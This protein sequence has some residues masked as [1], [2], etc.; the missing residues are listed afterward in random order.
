MIVIKP[1][2]R[3]FLR[4]DT[5][6]YLYANLHSGIVTGLQPLRHF[7]R[8]VPP[9]VPPCL[10]YSITAD[11]CCR[12]DAP[13]NP[14]GRPDT[15]CRS[16]ATA[17]SV[18]EVPSAGRPAA[19]TSGSTT[20]SAARCSARRRSCSASSRGCATARLGVRQLHCQLQIR[21]AQGT[22]PAGILQT[23]AGGAQV[24]PV[25]RGF[26]LLLQHPFYVPRQHG[27]RPFFIK[28]SQHNQHSPLQWRRSAALGHYLS[29]S[30]QMRFLEAL[31]VGVNELLSLYGISLRHSHFMASS[32]QKIS[33][34]PASADSAEINRAPAVQIAFPDASFR[35]PGQL[36]IAE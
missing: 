6:I 7:Q 17:R 21:G 22:Q 23:T 2:W 19:G 35:K 28:G 10:L 1:C 12:R 33:T 31:K 18:A 29:S 27:S 14:H 13:Q 36:F 8:I 25:D 9:G 34:A 11:R 32:C 5:F 26:P 4:G 3:C 20:T 24:W 16:A 30:G 15:L